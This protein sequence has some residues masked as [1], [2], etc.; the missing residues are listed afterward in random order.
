MVFTL[1]RR[2]VAKNSV[3]VAT[4]LGE[5]NEPDA[6]APL[7]R[8]LTHENALSH[9]DGEA[10]QWAPHGGGAVHEVRPL[11]GPNVSVPRHAHVG[12]FGWART[13]LKQLLLGRVREFRPNSR[14]SLFLY[15]F[16]SFSFLISY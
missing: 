11:S 9:E 8:G 14:F 15:F 10:G 16:Y 7:G 13:G 1:V 5:G 12:V 2:T 4:D 3:F 6:W